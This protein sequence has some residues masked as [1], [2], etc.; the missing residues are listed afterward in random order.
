M[1]SRGRSSTEDGIVDVDAAL[2]VGELLLLLLICMV[3]VDGRGGEGV[4]EGEGGRPG[5]DKRRRAMVGSE[6]Q[7][8]MGL[9]VEVESLL[10]I[11]FL[12]SVKGGERWLI[13]EVVVGEVSFAAMGGIA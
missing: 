10:S 7:R 4:G 1:Y 5:M 2:A 12:G 9:K 6:K 11:D 8:R 13:I 3:G